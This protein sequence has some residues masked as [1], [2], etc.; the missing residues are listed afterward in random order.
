MSRHA[1]LTV[2][3]QPHLICARPITG[4]QLFYEEEDYLS[5]LYLLDELARTHLIDLFGYCLHPSELRLLLSPSQCSVSRVMQRV[6]TSHTLRINHKQN[7]LG[8]LFR[9]RFESRLLDDTE[10]L[11]AIRNVH[12]WPVRK[13]LV[14]RPENYAWSSHSVYLDLG[15]SLGKS[16]AASEILEHF[17]ENQVA[18]RRAFARYVESAA[19]ESEEPL[20]VNK[21]LEVKKPGKRP[22]RI[23][24]T[25]LAKRVG[26]LLNI[27]TSLLSSISR[28][29]DLVVARRLFSTAAVMNMSRTV[30]EVAEFLK[31]DKAQVSRLVSQGLDLVYKDEPFKLLFNSV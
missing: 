28:R 10:V 9:G 11:E 17:S 8:P 19:L 16:M 12:L 3:G 5:Y 25:A 7:R 30:T 23:S 2:L 1:R 26:L 22:K 24:L 14:R 13:G 15:S 4:T 31:R 6:H 18:A 27:E 29:Q 21:A 20:G